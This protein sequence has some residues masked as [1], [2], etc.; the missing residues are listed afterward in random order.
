[1]VTTV[2]YALANGPWKL[3]LRN[4][5]GQFRVSNSDPGSRGLHAVHDRLD[6]VCADCPLSTVRSHGATGVP[7]LRRTAYVADHLG[8]SASDVDRSSHRRS[9]VVFLCRRTIG[10]EIM[11]WSGS[12]G[13]HLAFYRHPPGAVSQHSGRR[14]R[15]DGSSTTGNEQLGSNVGMEPPGRAGALDAVRVDF[16]KIGKPSRRFLMWTTPYRIERRRGRI[17][18][19]L[20]CRRLV[21]WRFP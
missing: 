5:D 17:A 15:C 10:F 14:V 3:G 6:L 13:F 21:F 12:T 19:V 18:A 2:P 9:P 4:F 8:R 7:N 20:C 16:R 11:A 1:M